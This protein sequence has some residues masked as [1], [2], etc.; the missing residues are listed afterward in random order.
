MNPAEF[1]G[2]L[3]RYPDLLAGLPEHLGEVVRI[4]RRI[5]D[6]EASPDEVDWWVGKGL[7]DV[8]RARLFDELHPPP[9]SP[10][11]VVMEGA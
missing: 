3:D 1:L 4:A 10:A 6:I 5:L 2:V 11:E 8:E 7:P 9:A